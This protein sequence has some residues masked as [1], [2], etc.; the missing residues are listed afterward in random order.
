MNG[1]YR[2]KEMRKETYRQREQQDAGV[3]ETWA[4]PVS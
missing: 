2:G 3:E 1:D 4:D